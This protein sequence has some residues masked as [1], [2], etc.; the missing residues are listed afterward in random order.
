MS[1]LLEVQED[2]KKVS[3]QKQ[4]E[5]TNALRKQHEKENASSEAKWRKEKANLEATQVKN[6]EEFQKCPS[7]IVDALEKEI[8][9]FKRK[10]VFKKCLLSRL[11]WRNRAVN[12]WT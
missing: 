10:K 8:A 12:N 3:L 2:E 6:R 4:K 7:L 11:Q 5:E 9:S 1:S